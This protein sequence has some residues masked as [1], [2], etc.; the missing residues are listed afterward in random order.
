MTADIATNA[1]ARIG[2]R[3]TRRLRSHG[4]VCLAAILLATG[5]PAQIIP[6]GNPAA[7]ILLS[8][9]IAEQRVFVT[10]SS[11]DGYAH[12]FVVEAWL[13]DVEAATEVLAR[14]GVPVQAIAAFTTAARPENLLPADDTPYS[15]VRQFCAA[16][17]D[18]QTTVAR[19]DFT[20][21]LLKLPRA[22][23]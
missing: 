7:D 6:T 19:L 5:A 9:A 10:C 14:N 17:P 13:K 15:E 4:A 1:H 23:E 18:W 11:L 12:P 8:Q 16:H 20:I 2:S 21:L 3:P 22:F